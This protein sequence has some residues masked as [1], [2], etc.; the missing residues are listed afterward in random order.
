MSEIT[1]DLFNSAVEEAVYIEDTTK[2]NSDTTNKYPE[3]FIPGEYLAHITDAD[4]RVV[5]VKAGKYK[6]RVY[7]FRVTVATENDKLSYKTEDWDGND[8]TVDGKEYTGR[9][10]KAS[11]VF[12]FLE[13]KEGDEFESNSGENDRYLRFCEVLGVAPKTDTRVIGGKE[14]AVKL[15]PNLEVDNLIG[16]PVLAVCNFQKKTWTDKNTGKER[17]SFEVKFVKIWNGG[18]IRHPQPT[19]PPDDLPF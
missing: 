18:E 17:R 11:G 7:N 13:P 15:L 6:A 2:K 14:T 1:T 5:D 4:T 16:K 10:I 19:M 3:R 9:T 12:K 8:K